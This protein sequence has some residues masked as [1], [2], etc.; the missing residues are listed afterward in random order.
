MVDGA[1]AD[2]GIV[3]TANNRFKRIDI[4]GGISVKLHIADMTGIGQGVVWRF[5]LNLF[6]GSDVVPYWNVE[7]VGIIILVGN[8][9][10][11]AEAFFYPCG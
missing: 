5:L 2:A 3:H 4:V 9:G 10:D 11:D 7:G 6:K 8:A 1:I